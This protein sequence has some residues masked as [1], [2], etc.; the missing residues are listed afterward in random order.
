[1]IVGN[2][3][4]SHAYLPVT[5][6]LEGQPNLSIEFVVDTGFVGYLTLP[7]AV[8]AALGLPYEFDTPANLAD[9]SEVQMAVHG[10]T[11]I[12]DGLERI[13]RVLATSKRP[14]LGMMLL[15]GQ[16]LKVQCADGEEVT[17]DSLL[18]A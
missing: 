14:L 13:V 12:W 16:E 1:M 15:A 10:A 2:V 17:V 5:Y 3:L 8:V 6:R 7:S 11:I 9:D 18:L 4:N